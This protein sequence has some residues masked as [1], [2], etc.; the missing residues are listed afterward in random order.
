MI[1]PVLLMGRGLLPPRKAKH[2]VGSCSSEKI[3][4]PLK[5]LPSRIVFLPSRFGNPVFLKTLFDTEHPFIP[6]VKKNALTIR[7]Y[8][9]GRY[10][11]NSVAFI[12]KDLYFIAI[13]GYCY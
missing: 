13:I 8:T 5:Y 9:D 2:G 7:E 3:P 11:G 10:S 12:G 4:R 6:M 1:A